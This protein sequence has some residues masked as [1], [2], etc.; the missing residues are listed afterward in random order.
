MSA[1]THHATAWTACGTTASIHTIV[2]WA[3]R[4][5]LTLTSCLP[6]AAAAVQCCC[7]GSLI[8]ASC[9]HDEGL[10][11]Q[12][13]PDRQC[14]GLPGYTHFNGCDVSCRRGCAA[15]AAA[16]SGRLAPLRTKQCLLWCDKHCMLRVP[17]GKRPCARDRTTWHRNVKFEG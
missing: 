12:K 11:L 16:T 3:I 10:M 5:T 13:R 7:W 4:W 17:S 14:S 8:A 2:N 15:A 9:L 1:D 6:G